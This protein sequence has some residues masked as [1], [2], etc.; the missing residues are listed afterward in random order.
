[1]SPTPNLNGTSECDVIWIQG[2][3]R[4]TQIKVEVIR[5]GPNPT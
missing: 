2:L 3:Y 1:M 4:G 5:V